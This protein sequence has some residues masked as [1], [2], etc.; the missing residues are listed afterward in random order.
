MA[1][2]QRRTSKTTHIEATRFIVSC[3][4]SSDGNE[5]RYPRVFD[6]SNVPKNKS[7]GMPV[8]LH[9]AREERIS[10]FAKMLNPD[11]IRD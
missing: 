5:L 4:S 6:P 2:T 11:E 7:R 8:T 10:A 9:A 3:L 1:R